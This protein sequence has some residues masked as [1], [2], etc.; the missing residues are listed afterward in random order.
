MVNLELLI[1][2]GMYLLVVTATWD[3]LSQWSIENL[4]YLLAISVDGVCQV[5]MLK[6]SVIGI[7]NCVDCYC[8]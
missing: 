5:V 3:F 2:N 4:G 1:V 6:V 7:I 8:C